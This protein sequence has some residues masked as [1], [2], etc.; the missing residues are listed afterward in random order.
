MVAEI[1]PRL[2]TNIIFSI[3]V[4]SLFTLKYHVLRIWIRHFISATKIRD[5][6]I[7]YSPFTGALDHV[8]VVQ[9]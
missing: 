9:Q 2:A 6:W 1:K 7:G 3:E 5:C 8:D 4:V